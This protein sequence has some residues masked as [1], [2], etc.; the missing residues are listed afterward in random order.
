[1][2]DLPKTEEEWLSRL[3]PEQFQVLRKAGTEPPFTGI[4]W[5]V[6]VDGVYTCAGC[7]TALFRSETKYDSGSGWPSFSEP[8][9]EGLIEE[10]EDRSGGR[11]RTEVVC[12]TCGGHLGHLFPD[13]PRPT[14]M[15]YCVNSASLNL[16]EEGE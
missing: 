10:R 15:R 12:A 2:T 7:G 3:S 11:T 8:V 16:E 13:G 14:G 9:A 6:K 4:Y 5:D 1:M